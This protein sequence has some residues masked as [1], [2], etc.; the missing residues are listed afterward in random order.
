MRVEEQIKELVRKDG[1]LYTK[2]VV[3]AG[4]RKEKLK[5]LL[6]EGLLMREARGI[7]SFSDQLTDEF[8]LIQVRCRKGIYS[9]ETALFFHGLTDQPPLQIAVTIPT[10]YC[11]NRIKEDFPHINFH[12]IKGSLWRVGITEQI[13]PQGGAIYLYDKERCVC[14][15]IR[16]KE[17][18]DPQVFKQ[19]ITEYFKDKERDSIRLMEYAKQFGITKKIREYMDMLI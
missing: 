19:S 6:E 1:F 13:S 3:A 17:K 15:I 5:E 9:H 7:Y 12:R 18:T 14:D 10:G 4:I 16:E 2:D 11:V 8:T